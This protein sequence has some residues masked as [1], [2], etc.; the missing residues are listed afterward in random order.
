MILGMHHLA[1]QIIIR[2]E[3]YMLMKSSMS[4][5]NPSVNAPPERDE[6]TV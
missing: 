5:L 3:A 2:K 4:P 6:V 1:G